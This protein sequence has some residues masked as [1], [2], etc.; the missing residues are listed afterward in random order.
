MEESYSQHAS[1]LN[2]PIMTLIPDD[3]GVM[4]DVGS[5]RGSWGFL[6][7]V[8]KKSQFLIGLDIW[9]P[10]LDKLNRLK[11]YDDLMRVCLPYL[12]FQ[13][14]SFDV[15]LASEVLEHL[16]HQDGLIFLNELDRV[17]RRRIIISTPL[18]LPQNR[19]VDGNPFN[20]HRSEWKPKELR[21]LGFEVKRIKRLPKTLA[22]TDK[23]RRMITR[24]KSKPSFWVA[25]KVKR[26]KR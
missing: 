21:R 14:K 16:T 23:F 5:G 19:I 2:K 12:P 1:V 15:T 25:V 3:C 24:M 4:L 11:V 26:K 8:Y 18:N 7:K 10:Y 13:E 22:F 6:I 20:K 17:T 9:K